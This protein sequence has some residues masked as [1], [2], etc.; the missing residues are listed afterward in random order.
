MADL[1]IWIKAARPRTLPLSLSGI[2]TGSA[3]AL[4]SGAFQMS[5]FLPA[6]STTLLLQ[7]LSNFAND[8]GD[9]SKGTDNEYRIGPSRMVQSGML[10]LA[11]MKRAIFLTAMLAFVS[12]ILL[13][14]FSFGWSKARYFALFIVLGLIAIWAAMQYTMGKRAYG[15]RGLGDLFVMLFFGFVA[16][17]GSYFLFSHQI[18]GLSLLLS[19]VIGSLATGVLHLNNMR[20]REQDLSSGKVTMAGILGPIRSRNYFTG[21][22]VLAVICI[23]LSAFFSTLN[24]LAFLPLISV[25]PLV[26]LLKRV[27]SVQESAKYNNYLKPLAL[28]TFFYSILLFITWSL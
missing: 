7:V 8:Y 5:I 9:A 3:L 11:E 23:I 20:D 24:F 17:T 15:Y 13:L 2:L 21:L 27:L 1:R 16:V 25:F 18:T 19:L 6:L 10:G 14:V 4:Q 26:I 22:I 28:N 12:G